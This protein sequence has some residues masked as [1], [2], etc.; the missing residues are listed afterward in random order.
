MRASKNTAR[1]AG[2]LYLLVIAGGIYSLK[3]VPDALVVSGDAAA[4]ARNIASSESTFR[5]AIYVGLVSEVLFLG[6]GLTLYALL[7]GAGRGLARAMLILVV[8]QVVLG[9]FDLT[10]Q[11]APLVLLSG[12][13]WLTAIPKP[14]LDV[15]ALGSL[16]LF[17]VGNQLAM[18]FWGLWLLPLGLLVNRSGF[19]P[20]V[21]GWLL[22][23]NC[24]SWIA[25]GFVALLFPVHAG[26]VDTILKVASI[27]EPVLTL[28]LLVMG[29]NVPPEAAA[30]A[31]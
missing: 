12:A 7:R 19:F 26:A 22:V 1:L 4:T 18:I 14:Q 25:T 24:F 29:A 15:L 16:G 10:F 5:L 31:A 3:I 9:V 6:V 23:L 20:R 11:A 30:A 17:D 8:I 2:L 21:I 27:G 13:G 28:W